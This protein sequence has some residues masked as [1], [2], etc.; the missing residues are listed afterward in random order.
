M[1]RDRP[2]ANLTQKLAAAVGRPASAARKLGAV[3]FHLTAIRRELWRV[4]EALG[5]IES[6][7]LQNLDSPRL[8]DHAFRA[9]SQF[10]E[11]GV[12][13][14][15]TRVVPVPSKTFVEFGV[16]S[17]REANTRFLLVKDG[18]AGLV[19][20]GDEGNIQ[21]IR[22]DPIYWLHNLKA[23]CAMVTR[24]NI[25]A[26]LREEGIGENLG[27]LSVD[28]DGVDWW[29]WEAITT[30]KPAIVAAEYNH[31]FGPDASVTVP[32]RPDFDRTKAH[33]SL[34][35][36]GASLRALERL[37]KRKGYDLVGTASGLNAFFVRR[38][39]RPDS[40]PARSV[41]EAFVDGGF[42]EYHDENGMRHRVGVDEQRRLVLSM[43]L[44]TVNEDGTAA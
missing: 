43:P 42:C 31:R 3:P 22:D 10:G 11:D 14:F 9:F 29:V 38:D 36:F 44:V 23:R 32:Y 20:D 16:E 7:Q 21:T 40:L 1:S 12:I 8:E 5:R 37:G 41:E 15:L 2:A 26:I 18:W 6:R 4:R 30:P 13:Q 19:L 33:H 35:Y 39:L 24:E 27:L 34:C 28:I 17:Y 25:D